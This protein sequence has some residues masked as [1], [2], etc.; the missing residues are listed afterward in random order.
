[1]EKIKI[2][3][4]MLLCSIIIIFTAC[5]EKNSDVQLVDDFQKQYAS[6]YTVVSE[7]ADGTC[8]ISLKAPDIGYI[9]EIMAEENDKKTLKNI[10]KIVDTCED[11]QIEYVFDVDEA[12]DDEIRDAFSNII[13]EELMRQAFDY[14][15]YEEEWSTGE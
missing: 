8:T 14:I 9:I 12:T 6:D 11:C 13:A 5:N 3:L 2:I 15:E 4:V 10:D 7:N 1:M